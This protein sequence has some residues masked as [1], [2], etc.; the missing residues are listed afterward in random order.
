[1]Q[2]L[3]FLDKLPDSLIRREGLIKKFM[4]KYPTGEDAV[5]LLDYFL[6]DKQV[7][8]E[9]EVDKIAKILG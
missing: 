1:M 6:K 9:I 4:V 2:Q 5:K 8:K 7:S 3:I